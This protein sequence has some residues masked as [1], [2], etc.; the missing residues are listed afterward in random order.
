MGKP[1]KVKKRRKEL[2]STGGSKRKKVRRSKESGEQSSTGQREDGHVDA[3]VQAASNIRSLADAIRED[4][5]NLPEGLREYDN[6]DVRNT[7]PLWTVVLQTLRE[8]KRV[9]LSWKPLEHPIGEITRTF[10]YLNL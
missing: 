4:L 6:D 2:D 1:E 7:D 3:D 9:R 5:V 8:L 10:L